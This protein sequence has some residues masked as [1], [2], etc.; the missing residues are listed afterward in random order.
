MRTSLLAAVA[1][2]LAGMAVRAVT[3]WFRDHGPAWDGIALNGNGAAVFLL[4]APVAV[5]A[6]EALCYHRGARLGML[7]V[8][9]AV[10][11]GTFLVA[12]GV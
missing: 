1:A 5:L 8:P 3:V 10:L 2:L 12:G 11:A 7:L 9:P 4:L 6:L